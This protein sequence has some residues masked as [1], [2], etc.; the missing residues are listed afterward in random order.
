MTGKTGEKCPESGIWRCTK[1]GNTIPLA[2]G[3]IFPP[4][5]RCHNTMWTLIRRA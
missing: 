2:K 1:C 3:N 5:A 4:C